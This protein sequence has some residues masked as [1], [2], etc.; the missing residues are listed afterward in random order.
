MI[1]IYEEGDQV[2]VMDDA[3]AG[4]CAACEVYLDKKV[5]ETQW[6]VYIAES[7][8]TELIGK[9]FIVSEEYFL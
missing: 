8:D 4:E 9:E 7:M 6:S 1:I 3:R 5:N 2:E